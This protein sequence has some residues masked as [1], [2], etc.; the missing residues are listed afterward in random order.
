MPVERMKLQIGDIRDDIS[1]DADRTRLWCRFVRAGRVRAAGN[2]Q[3]KITIDAAALSAAAAAG[4][5]NNKA[6][7]VDHAGWFDYPSLTKLAGSTFGSIWNSVEETVEGEIQ[8][9]DT[10]TGS[11]IADLVNEM[12][13]YPEK[14]PD[15]GLSIVFYPVWDREAEDGLSHIVGID[16]VE[17]VDFVFEPAA[18]GRVL[19]A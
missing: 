3:S 9:N 19:Q 12:F 5:F 15:I 6:V 17:S 14:S 8:L 2:R 13:Q 7:F 18:D 4:L 10:E 1:I 16:H 11:L